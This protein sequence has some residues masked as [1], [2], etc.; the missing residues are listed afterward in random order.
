MKNPTI[1]YY[2]LNAKKYIETTINIAA[3]EPIKSFCSQLKPNANILDV[4]CGSGRDSLYFINRG[5][6]VVAIDASKQLANLASAVIQQDVLVTSIENL[7]IE[8]EFD[9]VLCM[10]SLLHLKKNDLPSATKNCSKSLKENQEGLF[11]ASFKIGYGESY[12][13]NGRFF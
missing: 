2:D 12:D 11:F 7:K 5:F 1:N 6:S 10:A 8:N 9:A 3:G 4:G 13:D